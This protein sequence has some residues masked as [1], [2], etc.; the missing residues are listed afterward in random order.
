[1]HNRHPPP[2]VRALEAHLGSRDVARVI[3]GAVLGLALVVAL[4]RHPP[5]A[6]QTLGAVIATALAVGLAEVYSEFV[7]TEARE[8]RHIGRAEV[9]RLAAE[10]VPV[11]FGA[12][13]PA[14]FFLL[15]AAGVIE[16]QAAFTLAK[17]TGLALIC[18][19]GFLASRL[20][21]SGSGAA[22]LHASA[23][24]AIGGALIAVKAL[25]H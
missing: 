10:A 5:T 17:W 16:L 18:A 20:A 15:A 14:L 2:H 23:V 25:L 19:Y 3:Y 4:E 24:G 6:G 11:T 8:R 22:L 1:M 7:G 9:R 13:F 12:G 21:G